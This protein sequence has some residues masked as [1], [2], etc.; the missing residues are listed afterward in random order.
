MTPMT[1][2]KSF[3]LVG[4]NKCFVFAAS[5]RWAQAVHDVTSKPPGTIEC[6]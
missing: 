6:E 4:D 1:R 5:P 2:G 3:K